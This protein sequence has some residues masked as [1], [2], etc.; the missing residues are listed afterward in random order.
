MG[1]KATPSTV[2]EGGSS[3]CTAIQW[4]HAGTIVLWN[5]D[6][7]MSCYVYGKKKLLCYRYVTSLLVSISEE[8]PKSNPSACARYT[9]ICSCAVVPCPGGK[10]G[11]RGEGGVCVCEC[12][13]SQAQA[14][15][16]RKIV[17]S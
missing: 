15:H 9:S 17:T 12:V 1:R 16:G 8:E 10:G 11:G 5:K 2:C 4:Y 7:D 6:N 14:L 3:Q 13:C